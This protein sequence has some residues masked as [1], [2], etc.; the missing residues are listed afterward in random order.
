MKKT[1]DVLEH[2]KAVNASI[3]AIP[4]LG[5]SRKSLNE[6]ARRAFENGEELIC[7]RG[8]GQYKGQELTSGAVIKLSGISAYTSIDAGM[9]ISQ[10]TAKNQ[11]VLSKAQTLRDTVI[12]PA[13]K[14]YDDATQAA[15]N[16]VKRLAELQAAVLQAKG[17]VKETNEARCKAEAAL[18]V[19]LV[20]AEQ[21][22][23]AEPVIKPGVTISTPML[24]PE[25]TYFVGP[26]GLPRGENAEL[27]PVKTV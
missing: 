24:E 4:T 11:T 20:F 9:F 17:A 18:E 1:T 15:D 8:G 13:K 2:L 26:S 7:I 10:A 23:A 25:H 19:A 22:L 12:D 3:A 27:T 5:R 6:E 21:D 16:A 14:R